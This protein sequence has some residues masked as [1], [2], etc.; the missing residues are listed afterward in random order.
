MSNIIK[1]GANKRPELDTVIEN[2]MDDFLET[3]E[4]KAQILKAAYENAK[5]CVEENGLNIA[6]FSLHDDAQ[7]FLGQVLEFSLTNGIAFTLLDD[8]PEDDEKLEDLEYVHEIDCHVCMT[9][10]GQ[11]KISAHLGREDADGDKEMLVNGEWTRFYSFEQDGELKNCEYCDKKDDCLR[12]QVMHEEYDEEDF[13]F[14]PDE[15][16]DDPIYEMMTEKQ[17]ELIDEGDEDDSLLRVLTELKNGISDDEWEQ[18]KEKYASLLYLMH[19]FPLL[20]AT[21]DENGNVILKP[22]D[23]TDIY[24]YMI[25][26]NGDK[27]EL[28]QYI[29]PAMS[30]MCHYEDLDDWADDL[31]A[32]EHLG[33]EEYIRV[34]ASVD[35]PYDLYD[36]CCWAL[37]P[38]DEDKMM[39]EIPLS[40]GR[41]FWCEG[42]L[43]DKDY[44][45][46]TEAVNE[47]LEDEEAT[48]DEKKA[49]TDWLEAFKKYVK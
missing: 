12:Y 30:M 23:W 39:Y 19:E 5:A 7:R 42:R 6:D 3:A 9:E 16:E 49:A 38:S 11:C 26:Q 21:T 33:Q 25:R 45:K 13:G 41:S 44:E 20:E 15:L 48:E 36:F 10:E 34:V 4:A 31:D 28:C 22:A 27:V 47:V 32:E 14:D 35:D 24:G 8:F 1:F 37:E 17:Q 18:A 2:F 29:D 40:A 46:A 43:F